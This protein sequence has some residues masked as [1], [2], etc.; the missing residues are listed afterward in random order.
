MIPN[1]SHRQYRRF[2]QSH[3]PGSHERLL[4][5]TNRSGSALTVWSESFSSYYICLFILILSLLVQIETGKAA[6]TVS[7]NVTSWSHA[8][9]MVSLVNLRGIL[10]LAK[11]WNKDK[12]ENPSPVQQEQIKNNK[13]TDFYAPIGFAFLAFVV[14]CFGPGSFG[15]TAVFFLADLRGFRLCLIHLP[16]RNQRYCYCQISACIG[17]AV[18]RASVMCLLRV[19]FLPLPLF[20][21]CDV[22]AKNCLGPGPADS[23]SPP[24]FLSEDVSSL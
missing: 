17:H 15:P 6:G 1:E 8:F 5:F 12:I 14:V 18:A 16:V 13:H 21:P 20:I 11:S 10:T 24:L 22:L 2:H 9:K 23:F 3:W 7:F 19:P 4:H